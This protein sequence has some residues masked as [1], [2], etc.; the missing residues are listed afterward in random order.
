LI[1]QNRSRVG[2]S[3]AH[4]CA[5]R[6]FPEQSKKWQLVTTIALTGLVA[7]FLLLIL[8]PWPFKSQ[9]PW[10]GKDSNRVLTQTHELPPD[11]RVLAAQI[12]A[13]P[14]VEHKPI[15]V[16]KPER[17]TKASAN[18]LDKDLT[19]TGSEEPVNAFTQE[20]SFPRLLGQITAKKG[21]TI[22]VMISKIYGSFNVKYLKLVAFVNPHIKN[23]D[24]IEVGDM[25]NFPAIPITPD[26]LPEGWWVQITEKEKLENAYQFL[27]AYPKK[28]PP[29]RIIP[30]WNNQDGLKF[31]IVLQSNF[32]DEKSARS[33]MSLLP[34]MIASSSK[35]LKQWKEGTVF[36][37][38]LM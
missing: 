9:I 37:A 33:L 2:W 12:S 24:I 36:F 22:G 38:E 10:G 25:V 16:S 15:N 26:S 34:P 3:L 13:S 28:E 32:L 20:R 7:A 30:C 8:T 5:K 18:A 23:L 35:N 21:E 1:M 14:F 6:V 19:G 31:A 27:R 11:T 29:V 17:L 4:A